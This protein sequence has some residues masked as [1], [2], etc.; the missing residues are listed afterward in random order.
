MK[1]QDNNELLQRILTSDLAVKIS[2]DI[3]REKIE[4]RNKLV[5]EIE[6]LERSRP[7]KLHD[8][9]QQLDKAAEEIKT[10]Q[11]K[12]KQTEYRYNQNKQV[13]NEIQSNIDGQI[14]RLRR[15]LYTSA[16]ESIDHAIDELKEML[17]SVSHTKI[18]SVTRPKA[19][20]DKA[21][22]QIAKVFD[23]KMEGVIY[24]YYNNRQAIERRRAAIADAI[25]KLEQLKYSNCLNVK[26][27]IE[28]IKAGIPADHVEM[29]LLGEGIKVGG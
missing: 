3:E 28:E 18:M 26:V 9:R 1:A 11:H 22:D 25:R 17:H 24:Q 15:K 13:V 29:E 10:A 2:S 19:A 7:E 12:L 20:I 27:Q 16:P 6:K 23:T 14:H 5:T 4:A 8:A 21:T